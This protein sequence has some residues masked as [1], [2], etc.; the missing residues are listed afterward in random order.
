MEMQKNAAAA[1]V[2]EQ[3][4]QQQEAQNA[5]EQ[6]TPEEQ[7]AFTRLELG[8]KA[9][10]YKDKNAFNSIV[11]MLQTGAE[12]PAQTLAQAAITVFEMVDE[13]SGGTVP[14]SLIL[15]GAEVCLDLV[16]KVAEDTGVMQVDENMAAQALQQMLILAGDKYGFD[17]AELQGEIEGMDQN[18]VGQM[19]AEQEQIAGGGQQQQGEQQNG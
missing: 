5:E 11:K 3:Q 12:N 2:N 13:K 19:V 9:L 14:E 4:A 10:I 18:M 17:P 15:R 6:P 7:E 1:A 8:A 16:I